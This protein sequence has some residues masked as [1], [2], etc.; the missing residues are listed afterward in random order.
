L[1]YARDLLRN[2]FKS[3]TMSH[4]I[5]VIIGDITNSD[6]KNHMIAQLTLYMEDPMGGWEMTPE[7]ADKIIA[8]LITQ[9]NYLFFLAYY[10]GEIAGMA[11]CFINFS[12]FRGQQLL[13]IHDF[14]V[15][16][17][18]RKLGIGAALMQSIS[19]KSREMGFCK[20]TL[21]VRTDNP[22][23]RNLYLKTGFKECD[24]PMN[25]WILGL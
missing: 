8:G 4:D 18:Y 24:P 19:A 25:F 13:N 20:I 2:I 3:H 7:L 12:T 9:P 16:P 17:K 6:H 1:F 21:E 15:D 10:K 23:A 5:Q 11:N 22:K 14:A